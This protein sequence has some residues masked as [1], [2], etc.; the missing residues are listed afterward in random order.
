MLYSEIVRSN[1]FKATLKLLLL[2][3]TDHFG[4]QHQ[5]DKRHNAG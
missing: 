2:F 1:S 5:V 4:I 3:Q